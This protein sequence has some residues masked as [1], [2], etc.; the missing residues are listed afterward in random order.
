MIY[1]EK[2]DISPS[3]KYLIYFASK[4]FSKDPTYKVF[5]AFSEPPKFT[6]LTL[7]SHVADT[8]DGGGLFVDDSDTTIYFF[9][10]PYHSLEYMQQ[11]EPKHPNTLFK[12]D[13]RDLEDLRYPGGWVRVQNSSRLGKD[14]M[15]ETPGISECIH[16]SKKYSLICKHFGYGVNPYT[17]FDRTKFYL[18]KLLD[19]TEIVLSDVSFARFDQN[20]RLIIVRHGQILAYDVSDDLLE[21][22]LLIDLNNNKPPNFE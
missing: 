14:S 9:S 20:G 11:A 13:V 6:A 17:Q 7:W 3:G 22:S 5:T 15:Y 2:C 10:D 18:K 4:Y 1:P 12:I 19:D 21:P 8:W 16:Q